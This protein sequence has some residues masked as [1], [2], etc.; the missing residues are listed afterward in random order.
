M[1]S[2]TPIRRQE[3]YNDAPMTTR[4]HHAG[5]PKAKE[6]AEFVVTCFD[7]GLP[8]ETVFHVCF[9]TQDPPASIV[10]ALPGHTALTEQIIGSMP[11]PK[12]CA[13]SLCP[14]VQ[15]PFGEGEVAARSCM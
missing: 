15:R 6:N 4:P 1:N 13:K 11:S 5:S 9:H 12:R 8:D 3:P 2:L 14:W 7:M 10:A